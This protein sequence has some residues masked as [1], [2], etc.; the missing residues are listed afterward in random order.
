[1]GTRIMGTCFAAMGV[2]LH[3]AIAM[4]ADAATIT[5]TNTNDSGAGSLRQVLA[6]AN[7][8]ETINFAVTGTIMLTSGGLV[9]DKGVTIAGPGA[10]QLSVNGTQAAFQC[11]FSVV[12][13]EAVTISGLTITNG[14]GGICNSGATLIVSNCVVS[15]NASGGLGSSAFSNYSGT[16]SLTIANSTISDNSGPGV[17]NSSHHGP[18]IPTTVDSISTRRSA[19]ERPEGGGGNASLTIA[20]SIVR[21]NSGVGVSNGAYAAATTTILNSTL[22]GNSAGPEWGGGGGISTE[23]FEGYA[24]VTVSNSTISGNSAYG[25][26]GGIASDASFLTIINSTISGNS[27]YDGG[28]IFNIDFTVA[29]IVNSTISGN[30]AETTG[31]GIYNGDSSLHIANSTISGNSASSGGGIYNNQQQY[32]TSVVEISNTILNA[33]ASGENIF[34]NGGTVTSHGYNLSSDDGGGYL[35][36]SGD[37]INTDPLLS[38]LQDNGG[39]TLTHA[40]LPGS[41]AIN[42]GDPNFT[43]PPSYDQRGPDFYRVRDLNIDIGSFEVQAGI[44]PRQRP[45]PRLRPTPPR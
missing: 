21:D 32:F 7:N 11:V 19:R 28:G 43:P 45:T 42:A 38:P 8:G 1:M 5:V 35:T 29:T 9:I 13:G 31:G 26:G 25:G 24:T 4:R 14:D 6:G 34:N 12:S 15:D 33:G 40:L 2:L 18:A 27:G 39:P 37:Q 44:G 41:L 10:D 17:I 20:N 16:A 30:S 22:T 23:G 3:C 36:G